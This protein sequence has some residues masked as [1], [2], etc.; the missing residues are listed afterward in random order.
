MNT[1]RYLGTAFISSGKLEREMKKKI[2]ANKVVYQITASLKHSNVQIKVKKQVTETIFIPT[3]YYQGQNWTFSRRRRRSWQRQYSY[4]QCITIARLGH[5]LENT[6]KKN[7]HQNNE[8]AEKG[9][10]EETVRSDDIRSVIQTTPMLTVHWK[11]KT[12]QVCSSDGNEPY[13]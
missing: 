3:L 1:F 8:I 7:C 13:S 4:Q 11:R 10:K 12:E 2:Q 5:S 9:S 6:R